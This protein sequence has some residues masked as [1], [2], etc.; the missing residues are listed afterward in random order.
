MEEIRILGVSSSPRL[1]SNTAILVNAALEGASTIEGVTTKFVSLHG[2]HISPCVACDQCPV[3]GTYC[4]LKDD[5]Q[6]IYKALLWADGMVF[7]T[8]VYFQ[9]LNAQMKSLMDRC[10]PLVRLGSVLRFKIGGALAVG[11]GRNHGQEFAIHAVQDYFSVNNMLTVGAVRDAIGV[12]GFAWRKQKIRE[13]V[14]H[15]EV[16]GDVTTKENAFS[17]GK[18]VATCTKVFKEGSKIVNPQ[19]LYPEKTVIKRMEGG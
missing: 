8:P 7:G 1:G 10:R 18:L 15:S 12:S 9:T 16:Y 19:Q 13:D 14:I 4:V 2:K 3:E 17:L 11:G 5:M 6:E